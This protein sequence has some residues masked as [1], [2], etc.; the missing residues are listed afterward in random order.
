MVAKWN[1]VQK[2]VRQLPQSIQRLRYVEESLEIVVAA[3]EE[4]WWLAPGALPSDAVAPAAVPWC[5][6]RHAWR[7][8]GRITALCAY[9]GLVGTENG[10]VSLYRRASA[11]DDCGADVALDDSNLSR[12]FRA[13]PAL[14]S[15][16]VSAMAVVGIA[17]G[18]LAT[19]DGELLLLAEPLDAAAPTLY[20]RDGVG[21]V[22]LAA[23]QSPH[24][25]VTASRSGAIAVWD[26]RTPYRSRLERRTTMVA[27]SAFG[28]LR[29][30]TP[31]HSRILTL[32]LD[33]RRLVGGSEHGHLLEWDVRRPDVV[34]QV[35]RRHDGPVLEV[36]WVR[37]GTPRLGA[38]SCG[39][40][41]R[42][43]LGSDHQGA[44]R[45]VCGGPGTDY[46]RTVDVHRGG[47]LGCYGGDAGLL[48]EVFLQSG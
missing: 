33:E 41:G 16:S 47:E 44:E 35:A 43:Y 42:V 8:D 11:G 14:P 39:I 4:L 7:L 15:L 32:D 28:P 48:V 24:E 45:V 5:W 29:L 27:A 13:P 2:R 6:P 31:A 3:G 46:A 10:H 17:P 21:F 1:G 36:R 12:A 9:S 37:G 18:V 26:T 19:D 30:A 22:A 20:A 40:D 34:L 25:V 23:S 38:A